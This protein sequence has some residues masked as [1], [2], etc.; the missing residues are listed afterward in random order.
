MKKRNDMYLT[1]AE[2]QI[3]Q[4][5]WDLGEGLVKDVLEKLPDPKPVRNTVSTIIRILENKG[6]VSHRVYGNIH[7][8][9]P[10]VSKQSYSKNQ[11]LRLMENYFNNSFSTMASLFAQEKDLTVE[12]LD[13]I[14]EE[15]SREN[16]KEELK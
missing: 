7:L 9:F 15:L 11:L 8:Y 2:E 1:R 16:N 10:V 6:F 12:E 3:M 4:I 14:L 5:L 13:S